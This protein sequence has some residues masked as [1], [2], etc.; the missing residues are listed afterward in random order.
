[1]KRI[2]LIMLMVIGVLGCGGGSVMGRGP[3]AINRQIGNQSVALVFNISRGQVRVYCTGVWIGDNAILT[4]GH[5]IKGLVKHINEESLGEEKEVGVKV[6]YIVE[7]E[8]DGIMGEPT[9]IHLGTSVAVD[10]ESDLALIKAEGNLIPEHGQAELAGEAPGIGERVFVVGHPEGFYWSY[11]EGMVSGLRERM[12]GIN[13]VKGS[14]IQVSGPLYFGNSG[15]G[16]FDE[17]GRL[18]GIAS[19]TI[20]APHTGFFVH[21][22]NIREFL[23]KNK[24]LQR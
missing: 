7:R 21:L 23:K 2:I 15:G 1:M 6:H 16:C 8:V 12:V 24:N 10:E 3:T 17:G 5:C 14:F 19:F 11:V 18:V 4:A 9:G 22:N 13:E 20:S